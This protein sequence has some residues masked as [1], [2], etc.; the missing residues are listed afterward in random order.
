MDKEGGVIQNKHFVLTIIARAFLF[1]ILLNIFFIPIN[2]HVPYGKVSIYNN[3]FPGRERFPFG[4]NPDISYNLSINNFDAMFASHVVSA[5]INDRD[6]FRLFV[7]GDS[8]VWGIL[9][10]PE[11]TLPNLL[12]LHFGQLCPEKKIQV[13]NLGYPTLSLLKD[14][15]IIEYAQRFNPDMIIWPVTLE[16]FPLKTQLESPIIANN[17][18]YVKK[19]IQKFEFPIEIPQQNNNIF[20]DTIFL[21]RRNL[22]DLIRLQ[23]YGFLWAAT[24]IDQYYPQTYSPAQRDLDDSIEYKGFKPGELI[25]DDLSFEIIE[26]IIDKYQEIPFIIINEPILISKGENANYRYNYYYP[27]WAYD[28]YRELLRFR[29]GE[30]GIQY[31]DFWDFIPESEFTNSSIHITADAESKFANVILNNIY[32]NCK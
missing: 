25:E 17:F 4:E 19:L 11:V 13:F 22:A 16:S 30:K 6:T 24:G 23:L 1:F 15:L 20:K 32:M 3:I 18:R 12:A 5:K 21:H 9:L 10:E 27:R 8:S 28:Q 31:Y 14:A 26:N 2:R 29:M 7:V